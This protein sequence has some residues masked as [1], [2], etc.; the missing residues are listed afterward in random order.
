MQKV[1][2]GSLGEV[3]NPP[4]NAGDR[5]RRCGLDPWVRKIPFGGGNDNPLQYFCLEHSMDRGA[6]SAAV[7]G[8]TKEP[9][10]T[11]HTHTHTHT[12]T[13]IHMHT[14]SDLCHRDYI[15]LLL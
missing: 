14:H 11:E 3:K 15:H 7:H 10:M 1:W 13:H 2:S 9:D 8:A 6:W 5:C 12:H 4:A